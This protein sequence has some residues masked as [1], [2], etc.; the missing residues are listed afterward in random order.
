M[1]LKVNLKALIFLL[2]SVPVAAQ[3]LPDGSRANTPP[4][5][6]TADLALD[7]DLVAV[8][9]FDFVTT[10]ECVRRP[11]Y[12]CHEAELPSAMVKNPAVLGVFEAGETGLM[13]RGQRYLINH[14]H[15]KAAR[16]FIGNLDAELTLIDLHN[17]QIA[18]RK[19]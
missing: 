16:W 19:R 3:Q 1:K 14:G 15:R 13:L 18:R 4:L 12:I 11:S 5:L 7:F 2:A 10:S 17:W 8:R 9:S 6:T